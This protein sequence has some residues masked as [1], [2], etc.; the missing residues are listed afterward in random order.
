[1][2]VILGVLTPLLQLAVMVFGNA[3]LAKW[4]G[5]FRM[6]WDSRTSPALKAAIESEYQRLND[7]ATGAI[8]QRPP[9]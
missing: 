4:L 6:W 1:M 5:A 2:S 3:L 7:E 8:N 9:T